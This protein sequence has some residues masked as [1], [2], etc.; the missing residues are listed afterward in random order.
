MNDEELLKK[1]IESSACSCIDI[2][3]EFKPKSFN[4]LY[5]KVQYFEKNL[6]AL[7]YVLTQ[8]LNYIFSNGLTSSSADE[9]K[10]LKEF[11]YRENLSRAT[12]FMELHSAIS[13]C[14]IY[15]E[16][17]IRWYKDNIY[18]YKAGTFGVITSIVDGINTTLGYLV[19]T[20]KQPIK[21]VKIN[22]P[23]M[24]RRVLNND[25][26]IFLSP[27]DFCVL[28]TDPSLPHG[29]C[30]F[31]NDTLRLELLCEVYEK[32]L[33]DIRYDGPGRILIRPRNSVE[34]EDRGASQILSQSKQI[35]D[36]MNSD[37][38]KEAKRVGEELKNSKPDS[39]IMLSHGFDEKITHLPRVTKST[40][41]L[42]DIDNFLNNT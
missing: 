10:I 32:L 24:L 30:P 15:G 25:Q 3:A 8:S 5:D 13:I 38:Q 17:G 41:F 42:L 18:M 1:L 39:V 12:N 11:L 36:K 22:T 16:S 19:G 6:P 27:E 7:S 28:R 37:A 20:K 23:D 33:Y 26:Y 34:T 29:L 31:E 35:Q 9:I 4:T 21:D 2:G 40:E 14:M